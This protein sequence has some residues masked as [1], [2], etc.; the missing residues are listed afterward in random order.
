M[1]IFDQAHPKIIE[2]TF[3]LPE[4]VPALN[5]KNTIFAPF[6]YFL[7]QKRFSEISSPVTHN[8]I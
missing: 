4:F 8:F 6:S 5:L 3:S 1:A 2:W 7:L